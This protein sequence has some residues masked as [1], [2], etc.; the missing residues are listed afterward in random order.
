MTPVAIDTRLVRRHFDAHA[1]DY[2]RYALVQRRVVE[3]LAATC[4]VPLREG[5]AILDVGTGTG[6][7][8]RRLHRLAPRRPLVVSDLAHSMTRY[9]HI[10]LSASA[11]VDADA[12]ALPF[13][14]ASFGLVASSSVYQW[15]EDLDRAFTEVA[16][17]LL[18]GGWFAFALFGE[19]SLHE[20]KDS[21]RRALRDCGLER[22]SHL[23]EFPGREQTLAALEAAA[24]E[25]HELFVE[26][27][28]DCYGDVPQLLRALKKIGA[29]NASRQRPP[30]LASRRVMERMMEVY[31]RD[32]GAAEGI[33][34]S[35]EVI[36]GLARKPGQESP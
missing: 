3:R 2:D 9:A 5:G 6:L 16:R 11:A 14:A 34:A 21:H 27:E 23:Q 7:L 1:E 28:V 10:G 8:A 20:L 35:Y 24:F 12:V 19:N 31:R 33:P 30:G 32:Y 15:V 13:A 18:P 22:R 25:V 29:G 36:Y 4:A 17:V 26:E